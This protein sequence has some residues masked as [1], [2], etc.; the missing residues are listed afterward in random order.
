M[1]QMIKL[2]PK[3]GLSFGHFNE[4]SR[5]KKLKLKSKK[6]KTKKEFSQKTKNTVELHNSRLHNSRKL[7][8][9]RRFGGDQGFLYYKNP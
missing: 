1:I 4:N 8:N 6:T 2:Q 5:R 9:S 3:P 7:Q